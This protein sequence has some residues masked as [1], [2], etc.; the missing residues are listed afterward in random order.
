MFDSDIIINLGKY[1]FILYLIIFANF[2]GSLLDCKVQELF[3]NYLLVKNILGFLI[4]YFLITIA[5]NSNTYSLRKK[6]YISIIVYL[7]FIFST[8]IHHNAWYIMIIILAIV[9]VLH[10]LKDEKDDPVKQEQIKKAERLLV[11]LAGIV[12]IVG[13]IYYISQNKIDFVFQIKSCK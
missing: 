12:M 13:F 1:L 9:Y 6:F 7:I 8:K 10:L 2:L 11:I 5:D 4:V 3:S